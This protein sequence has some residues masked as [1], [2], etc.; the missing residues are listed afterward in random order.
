[1]KNSDSQLTQEQLITIVNDTEDILTPLLE[2]SLPKQRKCDACD[3]PM[4]LSVDP[5]EPFSTDSLLQNFIQ[6]C[7]V[8]GAI[9]RD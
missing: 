3:S 4:V 6:V 9:K 7:P 2:K 1:M 5:E 8:C